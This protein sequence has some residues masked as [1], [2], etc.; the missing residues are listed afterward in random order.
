MQSPLPSSHLS[1]ASNNSVIG[2]AVAFKKSNNKEV[3]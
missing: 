2:L 1:T 3:L